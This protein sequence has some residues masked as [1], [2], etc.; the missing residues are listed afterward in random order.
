MFT[1][2]PGILVNISLWSPEVESARQLY[3]H[4]KVHQLWVLSEYPSVQH[5]PAQFNTTT[6]PF[7]PPKSDSSTHPSFQQKTSVRNSREFN[8]KNRQF[9]KPV[10]STQKLFLTV[11]CVE[12]TGVLNWRFSCVEL[13]CVLNWRLF[14]VLNWQILGVKKEFLVEVMCRTDGCVELRGTHF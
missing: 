13:T 8:T 7:Q 10:S 4:I 3:I 9:D 11:C 5:R 12:L 1:Q 2:S 14:F 6:T